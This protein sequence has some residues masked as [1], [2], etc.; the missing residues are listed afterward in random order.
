MIKHPNE[1]T[2]SSG[3]F[4]RAV[5]FNDFYPLQTRL[6]LIVFVPSPT[7]LSFVHHESY[8]ERLQRQSFCS[9]TYAHPTATTPPQP[10]F[11]FFHEPGVF[12]SNPGLIIRKHNIL[13]PFYWRTQPVKTDQFFA[14]TRIWKQINAAAVITS[15][16]VCHYTL[17]LAERWRGATE[18]EEEEG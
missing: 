18:E 15:A 16:P 8:K 14:A 3:N 9:E 6:C 13:P 4:P 17:H 1:R 5:T 7:I 2:C 11:F 12:I 10:L